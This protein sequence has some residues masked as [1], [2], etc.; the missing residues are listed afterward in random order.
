MYIHMVG[1]CCNTERFVTF[2]DITGT[3]LEVA[4][5]KGNNA[6]CEN[7]CVNQ[8]VENGTPHWDGN[9][10]KDTQRGGSTVV[11]HLGRILT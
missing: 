3:P 4:S 9:G 8:H 5:H 2:L 11:Y 10:V 6:C 7:R 1:F